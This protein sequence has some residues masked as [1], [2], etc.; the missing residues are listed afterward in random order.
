MVMNADG[1]DARRLTQP[2]EIARQA[3]WSP[4]GRQFVYSM[5]SETFDLWLMRTDGSDKTLLLALSGDEA[6]P[7]F[8]PDGQHI[9]FVCSGCLGQQSSLFVISMSP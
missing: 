8:S 9:A 7:V 1:T 6:K 4:D 3:S 5:R 2:D